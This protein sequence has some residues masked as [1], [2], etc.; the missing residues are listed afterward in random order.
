MSWDCGV[1]IWPDIIIPDRMA[2]TDPQ[3]LSDVAVASPSF[4]FSTASSR[5]T[6]SCGLLVVNVVLVQKT[7]V[8][9]D[10]EPSTPQ[11]A[12]EGQV[13]P[14]LP[15]LGRPS[16]S[17]KRKRIAVACRPCRTRKSRVR[18]PS[19]AAVRVSVANKRCL[20]MRCS[21]MVDFP[22]RHATTPRRPAAMMIRAPANTPRRV[23][24]GL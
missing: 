22:A 5:P 10:S 20:C 9:A 15:N 19:R 21:V 1:E 7:G 23:I 16:E 17:R 24:L 4:R 6:K 13:L 8:M 14:Q 2:G 18:P 3:R 12:R 11:T